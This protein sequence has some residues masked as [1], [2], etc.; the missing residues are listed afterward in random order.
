MSSLQPTLA[1]AGVVLVPATADDLDALWAIWREPD[2]RRYLF[3]D[4]PVD[5]ARA[6]EVLDV[7]LAEAPRGL[8]LWTVRATDGADVVGC[9]GLM[10][11]GDVAIRDPALADMVEPVVA[12]APAVWHRGHAVAAL[13][14]L[15]RHAFTTLDLPRLA[16]AADVPNDASDRMLVRAGFVP[17]RECA[18]PKYRLRTYVLER[19]TEKEPT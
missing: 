2:V 11:V 15:V 14:A 8:G 12:L 18:G 4:A 7:C 17:Q 9:A 19:P 5:R 1:G 13:R 16:G 10:P 3:D 6:A